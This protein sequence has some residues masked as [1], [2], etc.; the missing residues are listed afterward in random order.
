MKVHP[1]AEV[2]PMME[3]EAFEEMVKS[4]EVWGQQVPCIKDGDVLIDGRN[5]HEACQ[6]LGI[7]TK[8]VEF[9]DVVK[10]YG[11]WSGRKHEYPL[12]SEFILAL[13]VQRRHLTDEQKTAVAM[14]WLPIYRSEAEEVKSQTKFKPGSSPNPGGKRKAEVDKDSC[15]PDPRRDIKEKH[16]NSTAGK[17]AKNTGLTL[18]QARQVIE[19]DKAAAAGVIPKEDLDAVIAGTTKPVEVLKKIEP[20]A[21]GKPKK[22]KILARLITLWKKATQEERNQ[23]MKEVE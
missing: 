5:R 1:A 23:F 17:L 4:I 2:F 19:I 9:R 16:A 8:F 18:H 10:N 11:H 22:S 21:T 15:P 14:K 13:N 12:I 6:H 3:G 7:A 20:K